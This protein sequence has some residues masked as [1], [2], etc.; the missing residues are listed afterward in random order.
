MAF[1]ADVSVAIAWFFKGQATDDTNVL[2]RRAGRERVHV[3]AY[4]AT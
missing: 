4:D 2:L 3:P 1:V